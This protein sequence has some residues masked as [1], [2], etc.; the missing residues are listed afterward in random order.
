[1]EVW[2]WHLLGQRSQINSEP[3]L[4]F[5]PIS[6]CLLQSLTQRKYTKR[7]DLPTPDNLGVSQRV[8]ALQLP[9]LR[10]ELGEA[11]DRAGAAVL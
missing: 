6:L 7:H 1:M 9:G 4:L 8:E 2:K 3:S 5:L 10:E 11:G